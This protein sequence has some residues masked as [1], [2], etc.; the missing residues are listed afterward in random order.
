MYKYLIVS[1][2]E[3]YNR[4]PIC[5]IQEKDLNKYG[6]GYEIYEV[7]KNGKLKLYKEFD[8]AN[9][10][11]FC[12]VLMHDTDDRSKW[13]ILEKYSV[14]SRENFIKTSVFKKWCNKYFYE[15]FDEIR[16][17]VLYE[18]GYC[19][20]NPEENADYA[21]TEFKDNLIYYPY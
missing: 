20:E 3:D 2:D 6:H 7:Q 12:V 21:I 5:L 17:N 8:V 19:S 10:R 9:N 4:E 13:T 16:K 1:C 15:D 14:D 11:G 18:G